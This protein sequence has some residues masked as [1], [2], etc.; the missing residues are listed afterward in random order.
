MPQLDEIYSRQQDADR[1]SEYL[2][3]GY[4]PLGWSGDPDLV[5]AFNNG[6]SQRWEML[7]HEPSRNLPNR[8][9][10]I[11]SGPP[12]AELNDSALF[13][14]IQ[15]LVSADTHREGNSAL[16][17]YDRMM[18]ENDRKEDA[19]EL[20]A[21]DATADALSKFYHEAGKALGVTKTNFAF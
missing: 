14:L 1:Y 21:A 8:H 3:N 20:A 9:V 7:R 2:H 16:E 19:R 11:M 4:A 6:P 17:Q 12:G 15:N 10:V 13:S 18:V 5:L